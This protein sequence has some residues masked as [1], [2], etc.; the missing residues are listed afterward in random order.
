MGFS[1]NPH[2]LP[3]LRDYNKADAW[4]KA[5]KPIRGKTI[6]PLGDRRHQQRQL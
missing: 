6:K 4:E 5:T 1:I 3:T 2:H